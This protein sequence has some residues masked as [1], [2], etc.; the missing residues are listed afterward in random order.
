M[1]YDDNKTEQKTEKE[2][3]DELIKSW[4]SKP[5]FLPELDLTKEERSFY[6]YYKKRL[7]EK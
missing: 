4:E 2:L 6:Y 1:G 5:N 3:I 7:G